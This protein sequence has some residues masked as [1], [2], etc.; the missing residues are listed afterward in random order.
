MPRR[1]EIR[2]RFHAQIADAA[3]RFRDHESMSQ[4]KVLKW[5]EQ[6]H[7]PDLECGIRVLQNIR[8]YSASQIRGLLR[9]LVRLAYQAFPG[10]PKSKIYFVPV[11]R[12]GGGAD[13]IA[14]PL[15]DVPGIR[16]NRIVHMLELNKLRSD[17]VGGIV[18]LDD[19]SGTGDT[20][21]T[22]WETVEMMV[23]PKNAPFLIAV[24]VLNHS[25]RVKILQFSQEV[26][27]G[28]LLSENENSLSPLSVNFTGPEKE[29]LV[30]YCTRTKSAEQYLRG[31]GDCGL[32]V[33]FRHGCPNN[34]LPILWHTANVWSP[35]FLRRG[36]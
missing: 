3:R 11:G 20:L 36:M 16:H 24:L 26:I 18:F 12:V 7:D 6:F 8:Y 22:W 29:T 9:T 34:S 17:E 2:A 27:S 23:R 35:L 5:I 25:A 30:A 4:N 1:A 32:L 21:V 10:I 14:R 31:Y 15:G 33:A 13:V 19:F 28:D